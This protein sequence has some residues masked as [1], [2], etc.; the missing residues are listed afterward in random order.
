FAP[1]APGAG[2]SA[3][4]P[5]TIDADAAS[6][7]AVPIDDD[8]AALRGAAARRIVVA[9]QRE[10]FG[11]VKLG[12][13]LFGWLTATGTAAILTGAVAGL[14]A[15]LGFDT[16]DRAVVITGVASESLGWFAVAILAA[17]L[18]VSYWCG[19]YVAARMARFNGAV[20]GLA[21]W[22]WAL[23]I[24]I[25]VSLVSVIIG[26]Q[27]DE[28]ADANVFPRITM[29]AEEFT[30]AGLIASAVVLIASLAG[31][32]LGGMSGTRY[33]RRVDRAGFAD[34]S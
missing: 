20:Q 12:S 17:I 1:A 23:V 8:E 27:I 26:S 18:L 25:V 5:D 13:A 4:R 29:T 31:A 11:G 10:A 30:V 15:V 19:G 7:D 16:P 6:V 32:V 24:A 14:G 9:R 34:A 28:V 3:G 22:V 33:H 2:P 21:V